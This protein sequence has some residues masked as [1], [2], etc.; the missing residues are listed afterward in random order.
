MSCFHHT[1]IKMGKNISCMVVQYTGRSFCWKLKIVTVITKWRRFMEPV[2]GTKPHSMYEKSDVKTNIIRYYFVAIHPMDKATS[3][4]EGQGWSRDT[5]DWMY[6]QSTCSHVCCARAGKIHVFWHLR[7]ICIF[8]TFSHVRH[9]TAC[10]S[11]S[12][13]RA[14]PHYTAPGHVM[15]VQ[16]QGSQLSPRC[17]V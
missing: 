14:R 12:R 1:I 5:L 3:G 15:A 9:V 7:P 10:V 2:R 4:T 6:L 13:V 11:A 8:R 17:G 16:W